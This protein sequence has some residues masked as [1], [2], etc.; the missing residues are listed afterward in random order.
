MVTIC[1]FDN[2]TPPTAVEYNVLSKEEI[3]VEVKSLKESLAV[4]EADICRIE[5][6]TREQK[7]SLK[8]FQYRRFRITASHFGDIR[9][10]RNTTQPQALVLRIIGAHPKEKKGS[11]SMVWGRS[12]ESLAL[13]KYKQEK[14]AL[15]CEHIVVTQSGLWVSPNYP[16][17]GAFLLLPQMQRSM[18]LLRHRH[19]VLQR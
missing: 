9:R 6:E 14:V 8:W 12:N 3:Q 1:T 13:E 18:T 17:L 15:G 7:D 11:V 10:R 16:F 4:S 5:K 19:L 2:S